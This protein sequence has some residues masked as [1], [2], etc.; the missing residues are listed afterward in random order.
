MIEWQ[1]GKFELRVGTDP[2]DEVDGRRWVS[3]RLSL[4]WPSLMGHEWHFGVSRYSLLVDGKQ[5]L[6]GRWRLSFYFGHRW[7]YCDKC[8]AKFEALRG[9]GSFETLIS[10]RCWAVRRALDS[11]KKRTIT[12]PSGK[13]RGA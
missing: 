7:H 8:I 1:R 5:M 9:R 12:S 4:W 11:C 3:R 10:E 13:E 6:S 2:S